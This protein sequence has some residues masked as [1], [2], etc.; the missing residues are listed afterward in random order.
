MPGILESVCDAAMT[1]PAR[2][3]ASPRRASQGIHRFVMWR[4]PRVAPCSGT[5]GGGLAE[6]LGELFGAAPGLR[7]VFGLDHDTNHGLGA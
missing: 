7:R 6:R 2:V 5:L 4:R 1:S 3:D